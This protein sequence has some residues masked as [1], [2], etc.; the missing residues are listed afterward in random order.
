L[1]YPV[2][3]IIRPPVLEGL[4]PLLVVNKVVDTPTDVTYG[5]AGFKGKICVAWMI[6]IDTESENRISSAHPIQQL[7]KRRLDFLD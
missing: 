3:R 4:N 6:G 2:L 1:P 5:G 7:G